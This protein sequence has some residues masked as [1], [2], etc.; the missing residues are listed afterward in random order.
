MY[1]PSTVFANRTADAKLR[2]FPRIEAA[3]IAPM[4]CLATAKLPVGPEWVW[5]I[6]LDGYWALGVKN[7]VHLAFTTTSSICCA[8]KVGT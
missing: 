1:P 8:A 5:E 7:A 3:F 4:E 2:N 6:K